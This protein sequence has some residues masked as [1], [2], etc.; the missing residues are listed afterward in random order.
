MAGAGLALVLVAGCGSA[1]DADVQR[2]AVAFED[3]AVGVQAR[4]A[5][6]APT[7]LTSLEQ[8]GPCSDELP[9]LPLHGGAVRSVQ[10]WGSD[11][12]VRLAG[13]TV[14]LDRTGAGW[15]VVAAGC[16]PRGDAPYECEV[17]GS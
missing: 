3:P 9:R 1:S 13:D 8:G 12:Q 6:L 11:A 15:R 14:F 10:V 4:C 7:A 17:E 2:V 5:L 16:R